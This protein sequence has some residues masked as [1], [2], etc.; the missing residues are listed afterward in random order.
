MS[1]R[2]AVGRI[3]LAELG[4]HPLHAEPVQQVEDHTRETTMQCQPNPPGKAM[5]HCPVIIL[6]MLMAFP[7]QAQVSRTPLQIAAEAQGQPGATIRL[8]NGLFLTTTLAIGSDDRKRADEVV[9]S[10]DDHTFNFYSLNNATTARHLLFF[11]TT[12]KNLKLG[13]V[14]GARGGNELVLCGWR[15]DIGWKG[16][17]LAGRDTDVAAFVQSFVDAPAGPAERRLTAG[18][19]APPASQPI[20]TVEGIVVRLSAGQNILEIMAGGQTVAVK[21][22]EVALVDASGRRS[23]LA[24]FKPGIAV[25]LTLEKVVVYALVGA[26][27]S[28]VPPSGTREFFE[29]TVSNLKKVPP[30]LAGA[31]PNARV[32]G[33]SQQN[34]T[35]VQLVEAPTAASQAAST[36]APASNKVT[37]TARNNGKMELSLLL[38]D[39]SGAKIDTKLRPGE[40]TTFQLFKGRCSGAWGSY[41]ADGRMLPGSSS[42]AGVFSVDQSETWVFTQKPSAFARDTQGWQ[43][44]TQITEGAKTAPGATIAVDGAVTKPA[45]PR[46]LPPEEQAA[47]EL[48]LARTYLSAG[49]KEQARQRL[50]R[51]VRNFPSTKAAAEASSLLNRE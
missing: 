44:E 29:T 13:K 31:P 46:V 50:E 8:P 7:L 49:L 35:R 3:S 39:S 17:S 47:S 26:G 6:T 37:I 10:R 15:E 40:T 34:V 2:P 51:I 27:K 12:G 25:R 18:P 22:D 33:W 42:Q 20:S 5:N 24:D 32:R 11:A 23:Q 1:S 48:R 4:E 41:G 16:I 30:N 43:R 45:P 19:D 38:T 21:I 14:P 9:I 28:A 36:V